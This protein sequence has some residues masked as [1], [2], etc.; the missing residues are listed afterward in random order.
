MDPGI[1]S[2]NRR[3]CRWKRRGFQEQQ[4]SRVVIMRIAPLEG[5]PAS[6][7]DIYSPQN[8]IRLKPTGCLCQKKEHSYV[9]L[10]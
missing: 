6:G 5:I 10:Y 2:P 9:L 3:R 4:R 1:F 7:K 8:N